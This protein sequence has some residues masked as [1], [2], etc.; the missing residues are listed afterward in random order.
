MSTDM[1]AHACKQ[2]HKHQ[3]TARRPWAG[4]A[5]S[6]SARRRARRRTRRRAR[7]R[8]PRARRC[9]PRASCRAQSGAPPFW[10]FF[11]ECVVFRQGGGGQ[12]RAPRSSRCRRRAAAPTPRSP[13]RASAQVPVARSRHTT[14]LS[15]VPHFKQTCVSQGSAIMSASATARS[16]VGKSHAGCPRLLR[17]A[18]S[19]CLSV[20]VVVT[21][22]FMCVPRD[23]G[24]PGGVDRGRAIGPMA[25]RARC[26]FLCSSALF[27][28][29][30]RTR[31]S[32]LCKL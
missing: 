7:T 16:A 19:S 21:A 29:T 5:T 15:Q 11:Q 6:P 8:R 18:R 20:L 23:H 30:S 10:G 26:A 17:L 28:N 9:P 22:I 24:C 1:S 32:V 4:T 3:R 12:K 27:L 2:T 13:A 14:V 25:F 31:A